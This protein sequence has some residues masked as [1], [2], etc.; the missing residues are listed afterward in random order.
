MAR[1]GYYTLVDV[2]FFVGD[3]EL[4]QGELEHAGYERTYEVSIP[5]SY[6]GDTHSV[7]LFLPRHGWTSAGQS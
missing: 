3:G 6:D 2:P 7:A 4:V 5:S 1:Q